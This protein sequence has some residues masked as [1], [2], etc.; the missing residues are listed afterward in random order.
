MSTKYEATVTEAPAILTIADY[1]KGSDE[2]VETT[3]PL[4]EPV[5]VPDGGLWAWMA[6]LGGYGV[7]HLIFA[8]ALITAF[9]R[10][11]HVL[12]VWVFHFVWDLPGLL[13]ASRC[14]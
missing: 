9:Q 2:A 13:R 10:M 1:E 4:N 14:R 6:V 8:R 11:H 3:L 12:H 7:H 5:S